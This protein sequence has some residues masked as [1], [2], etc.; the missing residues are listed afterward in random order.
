MTPLSLAAYGLVGAFCIQVVVHLTRATQ[1]SGL[2]ITQVVML[3]FNI[4][5]SGILT[6]A[7]FVFIDSS[8]VSPFLAA[9]YGLFAALVLQEIEDSVSTGT[10]TPIPT[11]YS[12]VAATPALILNGFFAV[13]GVGAF[14]A[15]AAEAYSFYQERKKQIN[16]PKSYWVIATILIVFG[17]GVTVLHGIENVSA[18]VAFQLGASAPLAYKQVKR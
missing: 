16:L 18:L 10:Q 12:L 7:Y 11:A 2:A 6:A 17:G 9:H 8:L 15:A 1:T 14:G 5:L 3:V 4:V 13:F